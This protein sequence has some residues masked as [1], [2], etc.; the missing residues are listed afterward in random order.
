M[1]TSRFAPGTWYPNDNA[2][3]AS[4][5][6]APP[7]L[8]NMSEQGVLDVDTIFAR[9][10]TTNPYQDEATRSAYFFSRR[11]VPLREPE[12]EEG[13]EHVWLQERSAPL[14]APTENIDAWVGWF[15]GGHPVSSSASAGRGPT[16]DFLEDY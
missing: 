14:Q 16:F 12:S 2:G 8:G 11:L 1:A 10:S 3:D 7:G 13:Y 5:I 15:L 6:G 9:A 4:S